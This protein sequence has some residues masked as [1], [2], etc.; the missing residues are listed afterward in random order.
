MREWRT[1]Y[2][3]ETRHAKLR[4]SQRAMEEETER[5]AEQAVREQ[6]ALELEE[7]QYQQEAAARQRLEISQQR[8]AAYVTKLEAEE[9][10][11][12]AAQAEQ[13]KLQEERQQQAA[14][15]R[16]AN[17][18]RA[19]AEQE[20]F[21]QR[22]EA[23]VAAAASHEQRRM[24][25]MRHEFK[26]A[27]RLNHFLP[28]EECNE[29]LTQQ[30]AQTQQR[31]RQ[32]RHLPEHH[33]V[34]TQK[35]QRLQ[36]QSEQQ[37]LERA[38]NDSIDGDVLWLQLAEGARTPAEVRH[39]FERR[40]DSFGATRERLSIQAITKVSN[41][42]ALRRF[43]SSGQFR[44]SPLATMDQPAGGGS[45]G[46]DSLL[47]HGCPEQAG[48]NIQAEGLS[49]RFA[50]DGMLGRGLYGAPDPRKSLNY[51]DEG[52]HGKFMFVCRFNLSAARHAGPMTADRNTV[53]SEFCVF[54]ECHVV[55]LWMLKV[56]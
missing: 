12:A 10:E 7:E 24:E 47:F 23:K 48:L 31:R 15:R 8:H 14:R 17:A 27:M 18:E 2:E 53:F 45:G 51:C 29:V 20:F 26:E 21:E 42:P 38:L 54:D 25:A 28:P 33:Q 16:K 1:A 43:H 22:Q 5:L 32:Q 35:Q 3:L 55:V 9:A 11:R 30:Q 56:F 19:R 34:L 41:V 40:Q 39:F 37:Q 4:A 46:A 52:R 6:V 36:Q 13:Q 44:I 49:L 50:A